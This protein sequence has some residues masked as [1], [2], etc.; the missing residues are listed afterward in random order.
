M[1]A[2]AW[3]TISAMALFNVIGVVFAIG[4]KNQL[5][6]EAMRRIGVM[7]QNKAEKEF[8]RLQVDRLDGEQRKQDD[9]ITS[10]RHDVKGLLQRREALRRE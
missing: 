4:I 10:V 7:E 6:N 2:E 5:L 1:P 8:V 9:E 3:I